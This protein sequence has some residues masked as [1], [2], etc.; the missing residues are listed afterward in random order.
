MGLNCLPVSNEEN[1][2]CT[3]RPIELKMINTQNSNYF[4]IKSDD[5]FK[6]QK[7][8]ISELKSKLT[9]LVNR[10][11]KIRTE[12]IKVL[13]NSE[14]CPDLTL[15]DLPGYDDKNKITSEIIFNY[16]KQESNII[17]F[18]ENAHSDTFIDQMKNLSSNKLLKLIE[19]TDKDFS[20]TIGVITK[21]DKLFLSG[22]LS[23][24]N[25]AI[26]LLKKLVS[27]ESSSMPFILVKN[28]ANSTTSIEDNQYKEREYFNT[29]IRS[30]NSNQCT[31]ETL[32]ENLKKKIF[33]NT[34]VKKNLVFLNKQLK[35]KIAECQK[36]L[37]QYGTDYLQYT[38]DTKN[39]YITS[40]LNNFCENL[41]KIFSGKM[42]ENN[43]NFA[44]YELKKIYNEFLKEKNKYNPSSVIKNEEVIKIIKLTE[45]DR[46]SGFPESEV[47]Y[48]LLEDEI[49]NLRNEVKIYLDSVNDIAR[50]TVKIQIQRI[51]CRFPKLFERVEELMNGFLEQVRILR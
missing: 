38:N 2:V 13:I 45:G 5:Q 49:E 44:N 47:I 23:G 30:I 20:R 35:D 8:D 39:T 3:K 41:E 48:T 6:G 27:I 22:S 4:E 16:A 42:P 32:S 17:V 9:E 14:R 28:R 7:Y 31:V 21:V 36:S 33:L 51:F 34:E 46:I 26:N 11:D 10:E 19:E 1:K 12:P 24:S 43:D 15:V 40:L 50:E 29:H 25:E 18:V 37:L